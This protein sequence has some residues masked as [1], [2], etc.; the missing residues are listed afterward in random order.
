MRSGMNK[1]V[2]L[3][4]VSVAITL[5][6]SNRVLYESNVGWQ[7]KLPIEAKEVY[8]ELYSE[9]YKYLLLLE[10]DIEQCTKQIYRYGKLFDLAYDILDLHDDYCDFLIRT[11]DL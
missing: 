5:L 9:A 11:Y 1:V 8:Y 10:K 3:S 7:R 6:T 4:K 2:L